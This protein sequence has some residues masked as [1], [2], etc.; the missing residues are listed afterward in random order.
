MSNHPCSNYPILD[1]NNAPRFQGSNNRAPEHHHVYIC[2][3]QY[4]LYFEK[5]SHD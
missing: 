1:W 5:T 3:N 2:R 4:G